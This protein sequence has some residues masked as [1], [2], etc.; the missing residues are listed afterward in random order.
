[1]TW[2]RRSGNTWTGTSIEMSER[3]FITV[4]DTGVE[5]TFQAGVSREALKRAQGTLR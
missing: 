4:I 5:Q 3:Q 1:M 2:F